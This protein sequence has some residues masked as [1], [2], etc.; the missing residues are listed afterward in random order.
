[1]QL[2]STQYII[3]LTR[4]KSDLVAEKHDFKWV[5]YATFLGVLC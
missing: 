1:M 5:P 4:L 2:E 3:I